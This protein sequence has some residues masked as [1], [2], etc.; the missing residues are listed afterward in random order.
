M[1]TI[2]KT[3]KF[4]TQKGV[5]FYCTVDCD[6]MASTNAGASWVTIPA[7][8]VDYVDINITVATNSVDVKVTTDCTGGVVLPTQTFTCAAGSTYNL[9]A[10]VKGTYPNVGVAYGSHVLTIKLDSTVDDNHG[11]C[12]GRI[13]LRGVRPA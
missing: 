13:T 3:S 2:T 9:S 6:S 7:Y 10:L 5:P 11:T 4:T 1:A 8:F 12:T